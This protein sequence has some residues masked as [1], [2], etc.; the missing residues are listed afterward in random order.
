[1]LLSAIEVGDVIWWLEKSCVDRQKGPIWLITKKDHVHHSEYRNLRL[2]TYSAL[3][4]RGFDFQTQSE[5]LL[6]DSSDENTVPGSYAVY[7]N[8]VNITPKRK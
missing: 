1:M 7:R 3:V 2:M 6:W 4:I 8:G 5:R